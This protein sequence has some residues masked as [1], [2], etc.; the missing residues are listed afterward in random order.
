MDD[1]TKGYEQRASKR[2]YCAHCRGDQ[3]HEDRFDPALAAW[4]SICTVCEMVELADDELAKRGRAYNAP[5]REDQRPKPSKK[6][7]T[8]ADTPADILGIGGLGA[9]D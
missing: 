1:V 9:V 8:I 6:P 4:V 3:K 7:D 2:T 5:V